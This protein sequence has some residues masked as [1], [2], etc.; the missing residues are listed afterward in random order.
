MLEQRCWEMSRAEGE[1]ESSLCA[2]ASS[3]SSPEESVVLTAADVLTSDSSQGTIM[4]GANSYRVPHVKGT[5]W[6]EG[7]A[8]DGRQMCKKFSKIRLQESLPPE[9]AQTHRNRHIDQKV[10]VQP[11]LVC[12]SG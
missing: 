2:D 10:I 7:G 12:P 11:L 6:E 9:L 3:V 1:N 4:S 5:L 8:A